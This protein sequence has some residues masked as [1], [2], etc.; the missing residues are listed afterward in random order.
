MIDIKLVARSFWRQ[1]KS[2]IPY[3]WL[4]QYHKCRY[5]KDRSPFQGLEM[6]EV[7]TQV[8]LSK[9]WLGKE[10][11]SGPGS[12]VN[13]A[14]QLAK[15]LEKVIEDFGIESLLD[16]PCGDAQWIQRVN[17]EN[18][19]Y[20]GADIVAE[21]I[22]SNIR[23]CGGSRQFI[24]L[25]L[26]SDDLPLVDLILVRDCF[27]HF[28]YADIFKSLINIRS[29]GIKYILMTTFTEHKLNYDIVSGDWRPLNLEAAPF[30]FPSFELVIAEPK[31]EGFENEHK[32]KSLGLWPVDQFLIDSL[33]NLKFH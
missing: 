29:T 2:L 31:F 4:E 12:E 32:G 20:I 5:S 13:H 27:V 3:L 25:D 11:I 14:S 10:S 17:F 24:Q 7:F 23:E 28:S 30:N 1:V 22:E 9:K 19:K 26:T 8:F 16:L 33:Q 15:D 21:L 18:C 6:E